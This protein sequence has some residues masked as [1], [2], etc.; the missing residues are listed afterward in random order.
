MSIRL[1]QDDLINKIAA[2]EV[3]E[4]PASV[5]KELLENAIDARPSRIAVRISGGGGRS[6]E[7]EDD[8]QGIPLAEIS[9]AFQRHATSKLSSESDLQQIL[10]MGFRGEAL[11]SI[12]AVAKV[13]VYSRH[14]E[15]NGLFFHMEGGKMQACEPRECLPGTRM[16][17][18]D[19]FFNTPARKHFQKSSVSE[20]ICINELVAR[21]ALARPDISISFS[22]E[23]RLYYKTPGNGQLKDAVIAVYGSSFLEQLL[24]FTYEG[25]KITLSGYISRPEFKKSNRKLQVFYIN[26]RPIRSPLLYRAI[27]QACQGFLVSREF[28]VAIVNIT[29]DPQEVDVN[30]HPQKTEVR[31]RR[32]QEVFRAVYEALKNCLEEYQVSF[33]GYKLSN[34]EGYAGTGLAEAMANQWISGGIP[35]FQSCAP[36][37]APPVRTKQT[38][39]EPQ[40]APEDVNS[41]NI[42]GQFHNSYILA[43]IE[44]SLFI[45]D[46]HAAHERIMFNRWQ[47]SQHSVQPC[48]ELMFPIILELSVSQIDLL[49]EQHRFFTELGFDI[50]I[51]GHNSI[52]IRGVPPGLNGHEE[53]TVVE[54]LYASEPGG[55]EQWRQKA[56]ISMA[57]HQAIKAG[58]N[59]SRAEMFNLIKD[60][61]AG[62]DH[63][64]C[65][66]GRPTLIKISSQDMERM[67]KR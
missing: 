27:D 66:H 5:V 44:R 22:S 23:G 29:I 4:R 45:V 19:L 21:Y 15:E 25:E 8:G 26:H 35:S 33:R 46:Q 51:L 31:F 41:L 36:P 43:E 2:G 34:A 52:I 6:I 64:Y 16:L 57:C 63:K 59:L 65:P 1:L 48:Q 61:L 39:P 60:L 13:Q 20:G 55:R 67:F 9:L 54:M 10:T 47:E 30:V 53:E 37:S 28:P 42:I 40:I 7:V 38:E 50:D 17:V 56:I 14:A 24:P 11:P 3:I 32:D 18:D 62:P 49:Q 12:A 58:Q